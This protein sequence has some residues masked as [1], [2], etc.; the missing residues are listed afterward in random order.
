MA[1]IKFEKFISISRQIL[2]I[3]LSINKLTLNWSAQ[4]KLDM[5]D[6]VPHDSL[7]ENMRHW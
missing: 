7:K 4:R 3:E 2:N 1:E 5:V 6:R